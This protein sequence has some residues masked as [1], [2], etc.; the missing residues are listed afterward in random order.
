MLVL[1]KHLSKNKFLSFFSQILPMS[2]IAIYGWLQKVM[3]YDILKSY[4]S[5]K[6]LNIISLN[7]SYW[8]WL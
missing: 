5:Y 7:L 6:S 3:R 4:L 2:F 1:E 8:E